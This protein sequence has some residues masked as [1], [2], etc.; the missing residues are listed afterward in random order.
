MK[1]FDP[2]YTFTLRGFDGRGCTGSLHDVTSNSAIVS[3]YFS[4]QAD[5]VVLNLF[6]VDDLFGHNPTSKYLPDFDVTGMTLTFRLACTN[7]QSPTSVMFESIPWGSLS[8]IKKD[9]TSGTIRLNP[10]SITGGTVASASFT[11]TGPTALPFSPVRLTYLSNVVYEIAQPAGSASVQYDYFNLFGTGYNHTITIDGTTWGYVQ[12]VGD[13]STDVAT[14]LAALIVDSRVTVSTSANS[15]ILTPN[16]NTGVA[17]ATNASDFNGPGS[18]LLINNVP[19]YI[20][21]QLQSQIN[22]TN[23]NLIGSPY[24]LTSTVSS[25]TVTIYAAD[26]SNN[27]KIGVDG[28]RIILYSSSDGGH[29][30]G[31]L[32]TTYL[33]GG[34]NETYADYSVNLNSLADLRVCWLTIA[35]L[36]AQGTAYSSQEFTYTLSNITLTGGVQDLYVANRLSSIINSDD[37]TGVALTY[38]GNW[39]TEMGSFV[40]GKARVASVL[41]DKV[42]IRY[43]YPVTHNLYL[44]TSLRNNTGRFSVK[45]DGFT[46][47][48]IDTYVNSVD[49]INSRRLLAS[50]VIPGEHEVTLTLLDNDPTYFDFLQV[51]TLTSPTDSTTFP[52]YSAAIDYD[53]DQTYKISPWRILDVFKKLGLRGDINFYAGVFFALKRIRKG[54]YFTECEIEIPSVSLGDTFFITIGGSTIGAQAYA[55]DTPDT[56]MERFRN[57]IHT[58]FVGIRCTLPSTGKIKIILLTPLNGFTISVSSSVTITLT[59]NLNA[60][61][62][63][64]WEVDSSAVNP[65]NKGFVDYLTNFCNLCVSESFTT[66]VAYSQELLNPPD[67]NTSV[68]AWTQRYNTGNAV[69]TATG[70]GTYGKGY[71]SAVSGSGTLTITVTGHG[72]KSGFLVRFNND[73]TTYK[74]TV[75]TADTF[76]ITTSNTINVNDIVYAVLQ[77]EHCTYNPS[78]FETYQKKVYLQTA[79]IMNTS[80]L[81]IQLQLGEILH[82]FFADGGSMAYYDEW[83][84]AKALM[85]LGRVLY[86]FTSPNNDP[87]VNSYQDADW[88]RSLV[89]NY[90][91]NIVTHVKG[92]YPSAEFELLWPYDVNYLTEYQNTTFPFNIGGQLNR[93]I[94]LPLQYETTGSDI[95]RIKVEALAWGTSYRNFD[96]AKTAIDILPNWPLNKRRYLSPLQNGGCPWKDEYKYATDRNI[97][98]HFWALDHIILFSWQLEFGQ[99]GGSFV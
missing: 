79:G 81:P 36:L 16:A 53:T 15:I 46:Y 80:T 55:S 3:G 74:I 73:L 45:V 64:T 47:S 83:M 11:V 30:I 31:S 68:N 24:G 95:D 39:P 76:Q 7:C 29:A 4:D 49:T 72:Y 85:D 33:T 22:S 1:K 23:W 87:S 92:T 5:F 8:Y 99:K 96:L 17:L 89:K 28:N 70:F 44:G 94:N 21:N 6:N 20:A 27:Q 88:L 84:K 19:V 51:C 67:Q 38:F 69:L 12:Q 78:T 40:N 60:G 66:T 59:G 41:G 93:Y 13:S 98:I 91:A 2:R 77:T 58:L 54:G 62:E 48:D 65:L 34:T 86:I 32:G 10:T 71:V 57:A 52:N 56:I 50:G 14:N 75:L 97:Q 61:N 82:W 9:E 42:I 37:T 35:P 63:G 18:L 43:S 90:C 26:Y 25:A